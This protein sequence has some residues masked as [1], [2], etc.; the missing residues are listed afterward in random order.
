MGFASVFTFDIISRAPP[1][2]M[3]LGSISSSAKILLIIFKETVRNPNG[4]FCLELSYLYFC[5]LKE[6]LKFSESVNLNY[7]CLLCVFWSLKEILEQ[8]KQRWQK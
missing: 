4:F 7:L 3:R 2:S 1:T 5:F 8:E 6:F